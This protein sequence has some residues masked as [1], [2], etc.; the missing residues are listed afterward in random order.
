MAMITAGTVAVLMNSLVAQA[1]LKDGIVAYWPLDEVVGTKTPDLVQ[2][3]DME[4]ANLTAGDLVD[5]K[6]GKAFKFENARQTLLRR[7][8]TPGE[9]LPINQFPAFTVSFWANVTGTGLT[10][11]RLFSEGSTTNNDPL[12]NL[13]TDSTGGTG[14][15][16][17]FLRRSGW[18]TVNHIKTES[19]PLDGTW[20]HIT[21]VQTDDGS[22]ALYF[23]G[24]K[25][26]LEIP[27]KEAGDWGVNT[28]T[29]GGIL[30]AN[31]THWL[32]G[33]MD[34][35]ALWN[36]A[37]TQTEI[38]QLVNEG[39]SS[40]FPPLAKGMVAYWPMD[41]VVG[42]K[43]PDLVNGYDLELANL[44]AADL[45]EGKHGKAFKFEN[46]RQ[47]LLR[48]V[49]SPGEQLPINQHPA[50]T[51]SLWVQVAGTGQTDLRLFSE[52]STSNNDPLFNLGT[53]NTGASDTLDVFLRRSGWTTVNHIKTEGT[54][55]DGTWRHIA[56]VQGGDGGRAIF[57]DGVKDP[58]EIP[59]KEA[60][61]WGVNTTTIGGILRANPTHWVTGQ[62]DDVA[63]W[64]RA[65]TAEE[66]ASVVKD[67]TPVPF[68]KPQ[69]LAIRSFTADFPATAVG[70]KVT[71]RWDVTKNVQVEIDQ[72]VGDVTSSTVSGLGSTEVTLQRSRTFRL[73]LRRDTETV[74][75][76]VTV[77]AIPEV[78][79]GWTLLDNF[80]RYE[81]GGLNGRGAWFDLTSN[82]FS[83]VDVDGNRMLAPN[84]ADTGAVLPLRSLT[85]KEG[86][87]ATLFF[88]TYL[89]GDPAEALRG[90]IVLTDRRLRFGNEANN[91]P[92]VRISDEIDD[93]DRLGG[94]NGYQGQLELMDPAL[95][96][97][98][99]YN[100]WVDIDNGPFEAGASTGDTYSIHVQKASGGARTTILA[101]YAADRDPVG[102]TDTGL[103]LPDLDSLAVL[104]RA[105]HSATQNLLFDDL[106]L[107]RGGFLATVPRAF[108]FSV[109]VSGE[110]PTLAVRRVGGQVEITYGGGT[111][112]SAGAP[113]GPWTGVA[114]ATS[115]YR[116]D[117]GGAQGYFRVKQ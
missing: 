65:L 110:P 89:R 50:L 54:P 101:Q 19:A 92:G 104:G 30:R 51:V 25:D 85:V 63:L 39:L 27:A 81:A 36:R 68:S 82:G 16:D 100:V 117:A 103:T 108:G 55:L 47:T 115:P 26:P 33:L 23:D 13:G 99:A 66:I 79:A 73:T 87:K 14:S 42:T 45:V 59:A 98:T 6:R 78:A 28:T 37:L 57:I 20:R 71:L 44:T 96:S 74:T 116:A 8:N 49:N 70:D 35:V 83:I 95:D 112:E 107:S 10:D 76:T 24:V 93:L 9:Q 102:T 7:V 111:L 86:Q 53:D 2:G 58:L 90:E 5:G 12:F 52:G 18:T 67:G 91:G 46:A 11:L 94:A 97:S 105:S 64:S 15:L 32:T 41:S 84:R 4:L 56:F 62:I 31:P 1:A 88:R 80:D 109:P 75:S 69:P 34:D 29:I 22:R 3:Y 114:G 43:T 40:V 113:T 17:V 61:D 77:A 21:F 72:G 48:R 60:G 106:Y 38:T